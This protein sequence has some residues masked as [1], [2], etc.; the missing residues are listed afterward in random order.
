MSLARVLLIV[1]FMPSELCLTMYSLL[2]FSDTLIPDD[3]DDDDWPPPV[4]LIEMVSFSFELP[5]DVDETF[6][7]VVWA[8]ASVGVDGGDS[9]LALWA[10][11]SLSIT[12]LNEPFR[13]LVA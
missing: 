6:G 7:S 5:D 13:V 11:F 1:I 2:F 12:A 3:D 10:D 9:S 4:A 8:E